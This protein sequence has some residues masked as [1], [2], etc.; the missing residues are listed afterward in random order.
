MNRYQNI[1]KRSV[2]KLL[3]LKINIRWATL[4]I[5]G[6][7]GNGS[8]WYDVAAEPAEQGK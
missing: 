6:R 2:R 7:Q 3:K 4:A 8:Q 1:A 5:I